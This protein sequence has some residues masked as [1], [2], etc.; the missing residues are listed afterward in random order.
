MWVPASP[1]PFAGRDKI[2]ACPGHSPPR[3]AALPPRPAGPALPPPS[4]R[5]RGPPV[6]A[7]GRQGAAK[8]GL[9]APAPRRPLWPS[10]HRG[11]RGRAF[12]VPLP[13]QWPRAPCP[14]PGRCRELPAWFWLSQAHLL[15]RRASDLSPRPCREKRCA[16]RGNGSEA[17][18]TRRRGAGRAPTLLCSAR[19]AWPRRD[20]AGLRGSGPDPVAERHRPPLPPCVLGT[21]SLVYPPVN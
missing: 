19:A 6:P 3:V 17:W 21:P 20:R 10:H 11:A 1:H 8:T 14:A 7:P 12:E 9:R 5:P 13:G 4:A 18:R 15:D 16:G 2:P